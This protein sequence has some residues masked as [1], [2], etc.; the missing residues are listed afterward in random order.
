LYATNNPAKAGLAGIVARMMNEDTK[1][2]TAEEFNSELDKLGSNI[3]VFAGSEEMIH[4]CFII[5]QKPAQNNDLVAR[6]IV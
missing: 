1:T 3:S 4:Q 6:E 2:Y 5:N